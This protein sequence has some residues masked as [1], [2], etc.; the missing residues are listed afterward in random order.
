MHLIH[1]ITIAEA[2]DYFERI[3]NFNGVEKITKHKR[4]LLIQSS[5]LIGI[6]RRGNKPLVLPRDNK[7]SGATTKMARRMP[8]RMNL[9]RE[10]PPV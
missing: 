7:A 10:K 5:H 1:G 4:I 8:S 9:K 3:M 6:F 2:K